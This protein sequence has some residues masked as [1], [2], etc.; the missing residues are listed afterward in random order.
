MLSDLT[1]IFL[2]S[3]FTIIGGITIY[4]AGQI[5]T[6][7]FIDPYHEYQKTVG[8]IADALVYYADV[9]SNPGSGDKQ[10]MDDA[11]RIFREKGSLLRVR[12]YAI[13]QY[14]WFVKRGW[15]PQWDIIMKAS[16][17]LIGLSNN[18]HRGDAKE[19]DLRRE[20]IIQ[21]LRLPPLRCPQGSDT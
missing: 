16:A 12:A 17:V 4:V 3:A 15:L 14:A 6:R 11:A 18:I 19:N 5:I 8:E 21:A 7:F 2:T 10:R 20:K 1:K 9:Y 13:P